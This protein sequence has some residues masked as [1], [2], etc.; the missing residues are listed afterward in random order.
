M[1]KLDT[2]VV[3][4]IETTGF[5]PLKEQIIEIGAV[6]ININGEVIER[7]SKFISLYRRET[8][9]E[10]ITEL[11]KID[12]ELL[13]EKGEDVKETIES[14]LNFAKDSILVAQNAKFD[15][16]FLT[17]YT[18]FAKKETNGQYFVDTINFSKVLFPEKKTHK[19]SSLVEYFEIEYDANA[20]HRADYDA[21]ITAKIFV[22]QM[23][24]LDMNSES[25]IEELLKKEC[26][27][28]PSEKQLSFLSNLIEQKGIS[29]NGM[30]FT[31]QTISTHIDMLMKIKNV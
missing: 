18:L 19:L 4:D 28:Q 9:P 3:F 6:K 29:E 24:Y 7:F 26:S 20:H 17:A 5:D 22:K 27:V 30:Y 11:T 8:V 21:E 2:F 23:E 25:S 16:S 12:D 13:L 31:K 10:I 1:S 14:F 15:M